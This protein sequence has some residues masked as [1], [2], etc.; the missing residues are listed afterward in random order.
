[1][2]DI[3]IPEEAAFET[4][5]A[6]LRTSSERLVPY[7][8]DA[9]V[10]ILTDGVLRAALPALRRQRAAE[11]AQAIKAAAD[12]HNAKIAGIAGVSHRDRDGMVSSGIRS[13]ARIVLDWSAE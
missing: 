8:S 2:S 5:R 7:L 3:V 1:V 11:V 9:D 10:D 13:A 4:I 12:A 6:A